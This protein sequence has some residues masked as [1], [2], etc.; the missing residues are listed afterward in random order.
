MVNGEGEVQADEALNQEITV[1]LQSNPKGLKITEMADRLGVPWQ[2]LIPSTRYLLEQGILI[3]EDKTYVLREA[4]DSENSED[5]PSQGEETLMTEETKTE[6]TKT[7][8]TCCQETSKE[9]QGVSS[10]YSPPPAYTGNLSCCSDQESLPTIAKF[11]LWVTFIIAVIALLIG[12]T[13]LKRFQH[14]QNATA[15]SLNELSIAST[16]ADRAQIE[17]VDALKYRMKALES[18]FSGLEN[19]VSRKVEVLELK[20][21]IIILEQLGDIAEGE[22]QSEADRIATEL[23]ALVNDI[24]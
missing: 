17:M 14:L 3:K 6:E 9:S 10:V 1:L 11:L 5:S 16:N 20:K 2:R 24:D 19:Q 7:E 18:G 15:S 8:E 22:V 13:S 23:R 21:A 4:T 12:T